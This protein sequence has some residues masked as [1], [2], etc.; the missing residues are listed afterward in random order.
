RVDDTVTGC[1]S[2]TTLELVVNALPVL[3]Q[4]TPLDLCDYDNPGDEL[5][6][7][8]LEDKID[9]ILNGQTGITLSFHET[10]AG[11]DTDTVEIFSPYVNTIANAQTIFVRAENNITGCVS[12]ITLDLRVE[13]LPS[14][15]T[16]TPLEVCDGDNDGVMDF[17]L[18][19]KTLEILNG[20]PDVT[21]TYHETVTDAENGVNVLTSPYENIVVDTQTIYVRAENDLTGC[22]RIVELQ[23]VVFPSPEVPLDIVDYVICDDNDDGFVQFDLT[24][25]DDDILGAQ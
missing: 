4:P 25:M 2:I 9:E 8:T 10:Q 14:P 22:Y 15:A 12:T 5:E 6:V 18:D 20:E 24:Q 21:I 19:S 11:A 1:S 16:P 7:F 13:P 17:D 23:L 3:V